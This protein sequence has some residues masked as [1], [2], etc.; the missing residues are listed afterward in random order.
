VGTLSVLKKRRQE[1]NMTQAE[2]AKAA[3]ISQPTYQN[4]ETGTIAIPPVKL[5]R[6]AKALKLDKCEILG[7]PPPVAPSLPYS[8]APLTNQYV[9]AEDDDAD[10]KNLEATDWEDEDHARAY[11]EELA[12][13]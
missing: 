12:G 11:W 1:L 13:C 7:L 2:V 4:Y 3:G 10:G 9:V 6:L 8:R 5:R